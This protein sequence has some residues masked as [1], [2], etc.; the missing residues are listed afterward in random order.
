MKILKSSSVLSLILLIF[1]TGY[2]GDLTLSGILTSNWHYINGSIITSGIT[3]INSGVSMDLIAQ[4]TISFNPGFKVN[5][6][7]T[8]E[9]STSP[10]TDTDLILDMVERRGGCSNYLLADSDGD[11]LIDSAEDVNRNGI[12]ELALNET[13]ACN[14]DTDGDQM[15]DGWE[16]SNGLNPLADDAAQ[17]P[18]GDGLANYYEYYFNSSDPLDGN[19]LPPKGTYYEYDDLGRIKKIIRIK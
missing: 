17:D 8:L 7:G 9:A 4:N 2:A 11:G 18:D 14:P 1:T 13:S 16:D 15:N 12:H 10:D 19:S 6:G 5:I 3:T